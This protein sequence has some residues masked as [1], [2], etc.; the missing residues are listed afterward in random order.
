MLLVECPGRISEVFEPGSDGDLDLY[1]DE[2]FGSMIPVAR[3][4]EALEEHSSIRAVSTTNIIE[5]IL[6]LS[7]GVS[8]ESRFRR[9]NFISNAVLDAS[10]ILG[11]YLFL[12][13]LILIYIF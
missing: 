3:V 10:L 5:V 6:H 12:E 13:S 1:I 11:L 4:G 9:E 2:T 7:L 8:F